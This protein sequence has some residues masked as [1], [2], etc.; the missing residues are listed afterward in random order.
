MFKDSLGKLTRNEDLTAA[1]V[2]EFIEDMRDDVVTEVQIAGFLVAL[3]MKGRTSTRWRRSC[4]RC[5]RTACRSS[6]RCTAT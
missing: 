5:A 1:E 4:G 2:T 3:V 6:P